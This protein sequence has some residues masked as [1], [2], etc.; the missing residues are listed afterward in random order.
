MSGDSAGDE[1]LIAV[2]VGTSGARAAAFD[3]AGR[4]VAEARRSYPTLTPRDGWAEQHAGHWRQASIGALAALVRGMQPGRPVVAIG[5]TGQCPTVAAVDAAGQPLRPA[6]IYRDNRA[7]AAA[8]ALRDQFGDS[9]LHARTGHV[10]TAFHLAAKIGWIRANEPAVFAAARH[11]LEP[12]EF[13][14][15]ALTGAASTDWTTAGASAL[16]DI[17]RREW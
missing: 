11:F 6:I 17:R 16:F 8:Q 10:P 14:A 2:D 1:V 7:T 5:L 12:S 15:L 9:D 4:P 13:V 3:L